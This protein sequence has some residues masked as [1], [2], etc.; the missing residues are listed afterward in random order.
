[1][2][3]R[4]E[5]FFDLVFVAISHQLSDAAAEHAGGAGLAQFILVS[6]LVTLM[7]FMNLTCYSLDVLV[8]IHHPSMTL[9]A[10]PQTQTM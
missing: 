2:P 10:N 7:S 6:V 8:R 3:S 1:V 5:L 9:N 4:F